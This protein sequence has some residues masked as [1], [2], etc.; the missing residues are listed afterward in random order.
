MDQVQ[1]HIYFGQ[2]CNCIITYLSLNPSKNQL[3]QPNHSP[4]DNAFDIPNTHECNTNK[5]SAIH[6][7]SSSLGAFYCKV[8]LCGLHMQFHVCVYKNSAM[9]SLQGHGSGPSQR[10]DSDREQMHH[11]QQSK[12][13][14]E[15]RQS[16][17]E[18]A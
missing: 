8:P 1:I 14:R 4:N 5:S 9:V 6:H 12:R 2:I 3:N 17:S 10:A 13:R 16:M 11:E 7:R 18:M 15:N